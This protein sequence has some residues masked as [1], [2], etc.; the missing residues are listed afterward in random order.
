M[1]RRIGKAFLLAAAAIFAAAPLAFGHETGK[2]AH[3]MM[4]GCDEHHAEALKASEQVSLHLA[5]AKRAETIAD[6][7]RHVELADKAMS[8][9]KTH[10]STCMEMME[11]MHGGGTH[12]GMMGS[13]TTSDEKKAAGKVVDPVCGM[14]VDPKTATSAT[15]QGKTYYFCSADDK[16]KFEKEPEKYVKKDG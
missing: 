12:G 15:Y 7:R 11:K 1:T 10:M 8:D 6:M 4:K 9:M 2:M 13:G 16:A 14:E 3:G 5:E